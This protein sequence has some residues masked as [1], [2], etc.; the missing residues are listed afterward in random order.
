[1]RGAQGRPMVAARLMA[2]AGGGLIVGV[3]DGIIE[4][5]RPRSTRASLGKFIPRFR[6]FD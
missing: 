1:M 4:A 5:R 3:T 6:P 2:A